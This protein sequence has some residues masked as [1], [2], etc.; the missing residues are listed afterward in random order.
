M[1]GHVL[2]ARRL[3]ERVVALQ[4]LGLLCG[5]EVEHRGKVER[6]GDDLFDDVGFF[7]IHKLPR[8]RPWE[9]LDGAPFVDV[10]A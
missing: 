6:L 5:V 4:H 9:L 3:C 1:R 7:E 2:V 10:D 8:P